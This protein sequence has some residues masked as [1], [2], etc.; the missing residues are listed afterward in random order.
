MKVEMAAERTARSANEIPNTCLF[1]WMALEPA[2]ISCVL[3]YTLAG[4][5]VS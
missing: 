3:R 2:P 5:Q 1:L 4:G